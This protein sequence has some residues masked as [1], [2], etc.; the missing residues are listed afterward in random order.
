VVESDCALGG[1]TTPA[2]TIPSVAIAVPGNAAEN[3]ARF[4]THDPPIVGR[5][6]NDEFR[7]DV[8]TLSDQ[9]LAAL[10]QVIMV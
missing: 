5:I 4:L 1:G 6:L 8:R 3:A 10:A 7:I 9:D 2:E